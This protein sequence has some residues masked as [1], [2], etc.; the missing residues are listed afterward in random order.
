MLNTIKINLSKHVLKRYEPEINSGTYFLYNALNK[1]TFNVDSQTGAIID[2]IDGNCS[3]DEIIDIICQNNKHLDKTK[4][5]DYLNSLF[6][7]LFLEGF[8]VEQD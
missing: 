5:E 7:E 4:L 1:K 6:N 2:C 8:I 3:V